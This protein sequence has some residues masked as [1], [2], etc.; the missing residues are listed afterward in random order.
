M[1]ALSVIL[2]CRDELPRMPAH[3]AKDAEIW[4][5][6]ADGWLVCLSAVWSFGLQ[7]TAVTLD[8]WPVGCWLGGAWS[9]QKCVEPVLC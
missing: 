3:P 6:Q 5:A 8:G 2:D 7:A 4:R 1:L 9:P